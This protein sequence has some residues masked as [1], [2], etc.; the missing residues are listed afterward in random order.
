ME[1]LKFKI[2]KKTTLHLKST[3]PVNYDDLIQLNFKDRWYFFNVTEVSH[4]KKTDSI[5]IN[6]EQT[7]SNYPIS[8]MIKGEDIFEFCNS[9]CSI[10]TEKNVIENV[11]EQ[12]LYC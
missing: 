1:L 4:Y 12:S 5:F 2:A 10:V 3:D 11:R 8:I 6:A 9:E 7:S